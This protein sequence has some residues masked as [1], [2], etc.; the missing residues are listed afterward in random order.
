MELI[1]FMV[2]AAAVRRI[3]FFKKA[4]A[5][6]FYKLMNGMGANTVFNHADYRLMS[7][8][9]LEGL[10]QFGEVNLF[11]RGIVPM[12][13]YRTD[14]VYY[15]RGERFAGESKYPLGKMLSFAV[16]GITS[17][18][19]KPIRMIT[20]LGFFVFLVSLIILVYSFVRHFMGATIVGWTTLMVSGMGNRWADFVITWGCWRIYW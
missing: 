18:S 12:I 16:E 1:L 6:G 13:G 7:R 9:A 19:T 15:E 11:L 5:E 2:S 8:R 17:L 3:P 14:V 4:T 20:G 10:A